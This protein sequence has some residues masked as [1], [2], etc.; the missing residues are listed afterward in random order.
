MSSRHDRMRLGE[1]LALRWAKVDLPGQRVSV[2]GTLACAE[3]A[4]T[5]TDTKTGR[6]RLL[7]LEPA[8]YGL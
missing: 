8:T 4:L 6:A 1:L 3:A 5:V 7:L 2:R